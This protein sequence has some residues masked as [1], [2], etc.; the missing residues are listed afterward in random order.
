LLFIRN[1]KATELFLWLGFKIIKDKMLF[2]DV[3]RIVADCFV[4]DDKRAN[5]RKN[6]KCENHIKH[7][8]NRADLYLCR[9]NRANSERTKEMEESLVYYFQCSAKENP[10]SIF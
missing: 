3:V 4:W 8:H 6:K 2:C 5:N 10:P 9:K 1:K 7:Y